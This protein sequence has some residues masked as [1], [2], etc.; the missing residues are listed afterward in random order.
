MC[1]FCN[2]RSIS[3]KTFFD[4]SRVEKEIEEVL[5]TVKSD[6]DVEIAF[7]GGSF[8]GIDRELMI[9]LLSLAQRYIDKGAASSIRLSTRPDYINEEILDILASYSVKTIEL[10]LQSMDDMVLEATMISVG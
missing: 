2:Q 5:S 4:I 7:F 3:G 1:V 6:D 8:T 9:S 10:G